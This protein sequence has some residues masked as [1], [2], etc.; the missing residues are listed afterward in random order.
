MTDENIILFDGI[1]KLDL[2]AD[3]VLLKAAQEA[4]LESTVIIGFTK[5]GDFYFA[6]SLADG[7]NVLWLLELAKRELFNK[8]DELAGDS[9]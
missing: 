9:A 4:D 1:T 6:S 7:G 3:R 5:D 8:A 2:P